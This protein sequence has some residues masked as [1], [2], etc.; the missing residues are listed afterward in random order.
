MR[1]VSGGARV[2]WPPRDLLRLRPNS[3]PRATAVDLTEEVRL[4]P[5]LRLQP[6]AARREHCGENLVR[7]RDDPPW[8]T[9]PSELAPEKW[10]PRGLAS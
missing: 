7:A 4:K 5:V 8:N 1:G 6:R 10:T 9:H 3:Q 2:E